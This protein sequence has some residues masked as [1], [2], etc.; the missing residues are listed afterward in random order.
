MSSRAS[1]GDGGRPAP[2]LTEPRGSALPESAGPPAVALRGSLDEVALF[3]VLRLLAAS[4]Q[5]G[6]LRIR[7]PFP[8]S[9]HLVGG[10]IGCVRADGSASLGD[11]LRRGGVEERAAPGRDP[12]VGRMLAVT[13]DPPR[14]ERLVREHVRDL[15]FE[16]AVLGEGPFEFTPGPPDPWSGAVTTDVA[17]AGD[18]HDRQVGEWREIAAT[19]PPASTRLVLV[20]R[21][22]DGVDEVAVSWDEWR[23][24]VLLD[25]R[26][27]VAELVA[28]C[29]LPALETSK[30][31]AGLLRKAVVAP[32]G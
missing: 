10:R 30:A 13:A 8:A 7:H 25:G 6:V 15:L 16:L 23:V 14:A 2:A 28:A 21:L 18:Q 3:D 12:N 11:A 32:A 17:E 19:L 9:V 29:D 20:P 27:T 26:H 24:L 31:L 1:A 5:T 4:P 22:A